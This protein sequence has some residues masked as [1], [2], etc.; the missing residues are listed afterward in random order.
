MQVWDVRRALQALRTLAI[1]KDAKDVRG[2]G[3][4]AALVLYTSS[5]EDVTTIGISELAES[6]SILYRY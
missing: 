5:Y 3:Q 2:A 6:M 1:A 4:Q